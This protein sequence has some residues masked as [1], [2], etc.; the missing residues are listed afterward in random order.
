MKSDKRNQQTEQLLI[1]SFIDLIKE[2][3]FNDIGVTDITRLAGVNRGTFYIHFSDKFD[4]LHKIERELLEKLQEALNSVIPTA[5]EQLKN[6]SFEI[7]PYKLVIKTLNQIYNDRD[8]VA[9]LLSSNGDPLFVNKLKDL[10]RKE[11]RVEFSQIKDSVFYDEVIPQDYIEE[12]ILNNLMSI[13]IHWLTKEHPEQPEEVA[14][15]ILRYREVSPDELIRIKK[16][17]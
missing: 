5:I 2:K 4:L 13:V 11:I 8:I 7:L 16:E 3:N 15:I 17:E 10:F 12:M 14:K 1:A 6:D 9:A